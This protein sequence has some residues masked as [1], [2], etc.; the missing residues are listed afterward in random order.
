MPRNNEWQSRIR[1]VEKEYVAMRQ[2]VDRF[3]QAALADPTILEADLRQGEITLAATNLEGTYIVRLFAEFESG[4]RQFW[5]ANW[6][7]YP[8]TVDLLDGLAARRGISD[9]ERDNAHIVREYRNA[10][11][12]E[13]DEAPDAV[14]IRVARGYL[15]TFFSRLPLQW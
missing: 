14:S 3:R 2:A 9:T 11:V 5:A 8:K 7:T 4:A 10:L 1:A 15:C 6:D 12:H 13:R